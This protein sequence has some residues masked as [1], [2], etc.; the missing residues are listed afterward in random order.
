MSTDRSCTATFDPP[1]QR[2]LDVTV[3][4]S[5]MGAAG[6]VTSDTGN[7][8]CPATSCTDMY[9]DGTVVTLTAAPTAPSTFN[10]WTGDC[11]AAGT[12]LAA[13]VTMTADRSC[14]A[15]FDP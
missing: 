15:T 14:T 7:I 11:S 1:V 3:T 2:Q 6:T 12:N 10:G 4:L 9:I 5:G 8:D 13:M